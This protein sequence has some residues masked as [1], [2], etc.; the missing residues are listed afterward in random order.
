MATNS[1]RARTGSCTTRTQHVYYFYCC[2][3]TLYVEGCRDRASHVSADIHVDSKHEIRAALLLYEAYNMN[4]YL[5]VT[6]ASYVRL[7]VDI[8]GCM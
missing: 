7:V 2:A 4:F 1:V 5:Y 6:Y 8:T 3:I